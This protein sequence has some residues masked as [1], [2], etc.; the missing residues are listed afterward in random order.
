VRKGL[1]ACKQVKV[2]YTLVQALRLCTGRTVKCTLVQALRLY[3]GPTVKCTLVQA[4]RLY[5]EPTVKCTLVQALRLYR[6]CT[7]KCNLVQALRLYI[8][9]T[10]HIGSGVTAL[11]FLDHGTRRGEESASHP[12]RSLPTG[13][14][15]YPLFMRL[16]RP[17][18]RSGQVRKIWPPLCPRTFQAVA[19]RYTVYAT[20]PTTN[21]PINQKL[22]KQ[23]TKNLTNYNEQILS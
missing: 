17:Q 18:G 10:A 6:S 1:T 12:S 7:V 4:L 22:N 2:K 11:L 13:K 14:N 16:G 8:G 15:Q 5:I 19:S 3:I 21:R 9:R 20:Q 23:L